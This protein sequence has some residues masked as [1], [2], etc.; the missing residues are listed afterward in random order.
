MDIEVREP[1]D[2]KERSQ[3][4]LAFAAGAFIV[5]LLAAGVVVATHFAQRHGPGAASERLPFGPAEQAY[6]GS[7]HFDDI[8]MSRSSNLLN[9]EFTYV[10]GTLSN[11]GSRTLR[12]LDVALEFHDPFNQ[13]ILRD[14]E[15]LLEPA[16]PPLGPGQQRDFQVTLEHVPAEWN[17]QVPDIRVTGLILE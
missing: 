10:A 1:T 6:S 12:G 13:L 4:P 8:H 9:Q 2:R 15:R 17:Q 5:L 14:T 11:G 3:F 7:I 16:S